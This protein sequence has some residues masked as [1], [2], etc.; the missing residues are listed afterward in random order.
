L[1]QLFPNC[2]IIHLILYTMKKKLFIAMAA[3]ICLNVNF[4]VQKAQAQNTNDEFIEDDAF[5]EPI[6]IIPNK[7]SNYAPNGGVFTPK[8]TLRCMVIYAGFY[9]PGNG[10]FNNQDVDNWDNLTNDDLDYNSVPQFVEEDRFHELIFT[11]A[12]DLN[13]PAYANVANLT[14]FYHEMSHGG[15]TII[16]DVFKDPETGQ[17]V[18][19]NI[20]PSGTTSNFPWDSWNKKVIE[21]GALLYPDFDWSDW[22]SRDNYPYYDSDNSTFFQ[23]QEPDYVIICWRYSKNWIMQPSSGSSF[24]KNTPSGYSTLGIP[25]TTTWNGNKFTSGFTNITSTTDIKGFMSLFIHEVAHELYECPHIMGAN[26]TMGNHFGM[27]ANGW[28]MMGPGSRVKTANAW[29]SWLLGWNELVTGET[30]ENSDIQ[31]P[32]DLNSTGEYILRDFVTYGDAIRIKIPN[33]TNTY[34]W[35]ENHQ[36]ESIFDHN[37]W[38]D[39]HPSPEGELIPDIDAGIYAFI[40]N[41]W[42]T[43]ESFN[44]N[45][46]MEKTNKIEVLNA[47]GNYEYTRSAYPL[48]IGNRI[49]NRYYWDNI[50]YNWTRGAQ[51]QIGGDKSSV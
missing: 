16:G 2:S 43:R 51:T 32:A 12:A 14:R 11:D 3:F 5:F 33:T 47:Q 4:A 25:N 44:L 17:P 24:V 28:G 9:I 46:T 6:T 13:N 38:K 27:P 35:L 49:D 23:D 36:K 50:I 30:A 48:M 42:P 39:G 31:S 34:L 26:S 21:K 8:G 40:E 15:F 19:I 7:T 20:D 37:P 22:D 45:I 41:V 1:S 29:E 10:A 18:R